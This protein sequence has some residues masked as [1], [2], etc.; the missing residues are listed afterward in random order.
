M[1]EV[2]L[3]VKAPN[4]KV[5][6][7]VIAKGWGSIAKVSVDKTS[8]DIGN[9]ER[10]ETPE[11]TQFKNRYLKYLEQQFSSKEPSSEAL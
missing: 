10:E 6:E 2:L 5:K 8:G 1:G 7:N 9:I 3:G 11:D 4:G